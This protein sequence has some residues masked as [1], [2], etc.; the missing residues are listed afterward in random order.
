MIRLIVHEWFW[1]GVCVV[2]AAFVVAAGIDAAVYY[3]WR[4]ITKR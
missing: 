3:L 4:K 1:I 2:L